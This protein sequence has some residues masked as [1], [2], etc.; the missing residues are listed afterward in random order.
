MYTCGELGAAPPRPRPR[1]G[2]DRVAPA[3][4][5]GGASA[6]E[7]GAPRALAEPPPPRMRAGTRVAAGNAGSPSGGDGRVDASGLAK[8]G[9][10]RD[11]P[12]GRRTTGC[13][14]GTAPRRAAGG[15]RAGCGASSAGASVGGVGVAREGNGNARAPP[16]PALPPPRPRPGGVATGRGE[17]S[18][19][20]EDSDSFVALSSD[21]AAAAAAEERAAADSARSRAERPPRGAG[22]PAAM[23][24]DGVRIAGMADRPGVGCVA[25]VAAAA[26]GVRAART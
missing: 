16:A 20:L 14:A 25:A 3:K 9:P 11:A 22:A 24:R 18:D 10:R 21:A 4:R 2:D 23:M 7:A 19:K 26:A 1:P 13:S 5:A 15:C 12:P 17:T 8:T 6:R